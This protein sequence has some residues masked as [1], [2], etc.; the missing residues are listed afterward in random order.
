MT[1][2]DNS[3]PYYPALDGLRG[4]AILL[5]VLYHNFAFLPFLN[6]GWLGVDLFF[7][8]SGFLITQI[9]MDTRNARNYF[10]NF[11]ARRIL[12]IFPLYYFFLFLFLII[13]PSFRGFPLDMSYYQK[14]QFWFWTYLQNWTLI[15][16]YNEKSNAL[17]HFWSLAVEEQYYLIWP[18]IIV[19]FK[20]P[21]TLLIFCFGLLAGVIMARLYIWNHKTLFP[22]YQWLFL[23]TRIDGI[24]IGSILA[25]VYYINQNI[26]RKYS[27]F[28]ILLL[29]SLNFA[30]YFIDK[31]QGFPIWPIAGFTT[32]S[33]IFALLVYETITKENRI[34][35]LILNNSVL[36]FFGKYSYGFYIFHWPVFLLAKPYTD[37]LTSKLTP[38]TGHWYLLSSAIMAT[39]AGLIAAII[40][41]HAF[42]KHFLKLK[43]F[44]A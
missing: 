16:R 5:V 7:V 41:F 38:A 11:Y 3:K 1:L 35:N 27:T 19:L 15:F 13:L 17:N 40:S 23:F 34:I 44:F 42:E 31:E 26:L 39:L 30:V 18:F 9:L 24:L 22:S 28:L 20:K 12:R 32:F 21:K 33:V 36:R 43:K 14:N 29:A 4:L 25:L 6:Y 8:I 37:K 10:K 2:K